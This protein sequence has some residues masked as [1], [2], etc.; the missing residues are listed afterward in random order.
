MLR[1]QSGVKIKTFKMLALVLKPSNRNTI[2]NWC[3]NVL[4]DTW[5]T[6]CKQIWL[7]SKSELLRCRIITRRLLQ[8]QKRKVRRIDRQSSNVFLLKIGWKSS[9]EWLTKITTRGRRELALS[10]SQLKIRSLQLSVASKDIVASTRLQRRL[11]MKTKI[12]TNL[13]CS[14]TSFANECGAL[15]WNSRWR[16]KW[17]AHSKLKVLSKRLG[18]RLDFL[19]YRILWIDSWLENRLTPNCWIK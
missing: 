18:P 4:I 19:M 11:L 5:S 2:S 17:N 12:Q 6:E 16:R 13:K 3:C 7:Q 1:K 15:F 9:W 8:L 14:R 10:R